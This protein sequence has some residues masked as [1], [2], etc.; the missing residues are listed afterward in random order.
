MPEL[1]DIALYLEHLERRASGKRLLGVRLGNPF[2]VR[3]VEPPLREAAGRAVTSVRRL[4][5]RIVL[6][7]EPD[8]F[9]VLHLMIAGRLHW[10]EPSGKLKDLW[11]RSCRKA[12]LAS[13]DFENGCLLLPRPARNA[14]PGYGSRGDTALAALDPGG[15]SA[16]GVSRAFARRSP[17]RPTP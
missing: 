13:F 11:P 17:A 1:P 14:G 8:L 10:K 4:G 6:G 16:H 12:R 7:L 15:S 9:L 5:K 3:S 2:L